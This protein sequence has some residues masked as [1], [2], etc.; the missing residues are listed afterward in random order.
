MA[1]E[2]FFRETKK[3]LGLDDYQV[4]SSLSIKRYLIRLMLIYTYCRM[5]VSNERLSLGTGIKKARDQVIKEQ[6]TWIFS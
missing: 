3:H 5:D 6:L 4:R 2:T 1:N